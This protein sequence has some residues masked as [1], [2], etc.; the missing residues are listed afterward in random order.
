MDIVVEIGNSHEGSLGIAQ[1]FVD[2]A[3]STGA[4]VVKFQLHLA[5]FEGT[6]TEPFRKKFSLQDST[7]Q[8][9]W[10]RVNF[11]PDQWIQ[12]ADY[13]RACGME[14]MCTPFSQ[15]AAS[16]LFER[17]LVSRWKVGS[18]D[19]AN[20]PLLDFLVNTKLPLIISTGLISWDEILVLRDF[21]ISRKAW[22]RTTLMHCVSSYPVNLDKVSFNVITDLRSL[23]CRVGYSDHSG[24]LSVPLL[25]TSMGIDCL[26]I[27]MTPHHLFFGPDTSS[28]LTPHEIKSLVE[29]YKDWSVIWNSPNPKSML[30]E[31]SKETA[32][33]F[34]KGIYWASNL[35]PGETVTISSVKFLKP[36]VGLDAMKYESIL[37]R[38][39]SRTV[40]SNDPVQESDFI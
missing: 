16:F 26:E 14:F 15:E 21:L 2:M 13:V 23:G 39:V 1:S 35:Q 29:F 19:A 38:K 8:D 20:F 32:R 33:I 4:N 18:G 11:T 28:S 7:R 17:G 25:A 12:I 36:L 37:G 40:T 31:E 30:F 10:K 22:T 3:K 27:H 6:P 9:Y 24:K 34:R 5:E